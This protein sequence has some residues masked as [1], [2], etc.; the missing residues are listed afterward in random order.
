MQ[1]TTRHRRPASSIF[2]SSR[3]ELDHIFLASRFNHFPAALEAGPE[4]ETVAGAHRACLAAVL[5]DHRNAGQDVAELPL[6]IFDAPFAGG[7]FPDAGVE[8]AVALLDI[9]GAEVWITRNQ[10]IRRR[11]AEFRF[12]AVRR[13][14][15]VMRG[16]DLPPT[17]SSQ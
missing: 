10:A 13:Y 6:V 4:H 11:R 15:Q 14:F 16:Q 1:C 12:D 2:R 7:R 9:P 5:G 17:V 3:S 8:A